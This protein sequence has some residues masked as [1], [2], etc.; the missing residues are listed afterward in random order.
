MPR[1]KFPRAFLA[2]C[3]VLILLTAAAPLANAAGHGKGGDH[4]KKADRSTVDSILKAIQESPVFNGKGKKFENDGDALEA[5]ANSLLKKLN[6]L[7]SGDPALTLAVNTYITAVDT[8]TATFQ[9]SIKAAKLTYK[10][11][12]AAATTDASKLSAET[13]YKAAIAAAQ[14]AFNTVVAAANLAFKTALTALL[15]IPT[16]RPSPS[17]SST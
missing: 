13:T 12:R 6:K 16:P 3:S 14:Q 10:S 11:A 9:S 2:A 17:P 7:S 4:G 5:Q 1:R 15:P 8:A